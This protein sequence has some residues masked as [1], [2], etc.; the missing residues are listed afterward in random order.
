M[1]RRG[2]SI[3]ALLLGGVLGGVPSALAQSGG[4]LF[5][6]NGLAYLF[7][8]NGTVAAPS[9]TFAAQGTNDGLYYD[10]VNGNVSMSFNGSQKWASDGG[11]AIRLADALAFPSA[12]AVTWSATTMFAG[13]ET[14]LYR[15]GVRTID[16]DNGA[17]TFNT[18]FRVGAVALAAREAITVDAATT[19]AITSGYITLACTGAETIN[20]I[21]GG[22]TGVL[23]TIEHTDTECTIADDDDATAANAVD[24]TGTATN[25]VGAVNKTIQLLYNGTFW[26]Q[27]G[28]S[29]N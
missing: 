29:D 8:S 14:R 10:T 26:M 25:D 28:E 15:S 18:I 13:V 24:L 6:I 2:L 20:T 12:G 23:L 7:L 5:R 21:T 22:V 27:T 16:L 9:L 11:A 3:L 17:G 4:G 19:F 1:T